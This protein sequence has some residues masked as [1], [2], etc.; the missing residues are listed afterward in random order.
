MRSLILAVIIALTGCIAKHKSD[1]NIIRSVEIKGVTV[2]IVDS[3]AEVKMANNYPY[4]DDSIYYA[5]AFY[6]PVD[7]VIWVPKNEI[8]DEN[9]KI[10][11]NL[12]L[13]GHEM[14]HVA[15]P[16]YHGRTNSS[17]TFPSLPGFDLI[18]RKK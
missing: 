9:G 11:P 3:I 2:N 5:L 8:E 1:D 13:L 7:N 14:W 15:E 6:D 16:G 12:F 10:M 17:Y 4:P 18:I